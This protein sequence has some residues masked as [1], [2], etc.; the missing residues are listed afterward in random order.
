M[1]KTAFIAIVGCPNVG[2]SS[3]L[4]KIMG[5]K[6]AIVSSKPQ[7]TRTKIMGVLT[8][9]DIQLVFTD[10]P[11]YHKPHN[12]LGEKM[13]QAVGDSI[14]GVDA[15]LFVV[16]SKGNIKKGEYELLE[17]FKNL[18]VPVILAINK[19]DMIKDKE[20][21]LE[22]IVQLNSLFDF[23][24]IV[25]VCAST[26]EHIDELVDEMKKLAFDSPHFFPDDTLTDQPERVLAS[27]II[28]EK[29]LRLMDK[30]V[31]HGIAVSIEKMRERDNQDILDIEAI[32]YCERES[33]KGMVIGKK[34]SMLKKISTYARQDLESFFG[35][36]VNLQTW[37]KV[38]E[39]WRNREGLIH[40]F[41]L[42]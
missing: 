15:C 5:T 26:G 20:E 11:G 3:I 27:E 6:I 42:D 41:G 31:P 17:K 37:V 4:N 21:L 9:G 28:R 29:I 24:A 12:K 30:E 14:G 13:N 23:E 19:I 18:K 35:I 33:H 16:E 38:K 8:E 40:N 10:T 25:P 2:K 39:D 1:T 34:G 36:K 32:I 22:R 7:T